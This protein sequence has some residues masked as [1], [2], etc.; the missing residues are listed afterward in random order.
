MA[1]YIRNLCYFLV[2]VNLC[3]DTKSSTGRFMLI[4][5]DAVTSFEQ[6]LLPESKAEGIALAKKKA[7]IEIEY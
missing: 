6:Q 7:S 4:M 1:N 3:I 5:I 2:V